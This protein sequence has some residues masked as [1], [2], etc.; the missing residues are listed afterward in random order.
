MST[1]PT[2]LILVFFIGVSFLSVY[3]AQGVDELSNK[4]S[5]KVDHQ[6]FN[7]LLKNH[8]STSGEVN[9][10]AFREHST[11]FSEYL[12]ILTKANPYAKNWSRNE[13]LAFWINAYNAF[14]IQLILDNMPLESIKDIYRPWNKKFFS[15]AGIEIDLNHVEHEILRKMN[16]PRIHFAIV[17][18]SYSCPQLR[19]EA[20][21]A[22]RLEEQ[23][24]QQASQFINDPKRNRI[25]KEAVELS[26]IFDW[27]TKDFTANGSLIDFINQYSKVK[28]SKDA[29]ISWLD[30]NWK[31]ND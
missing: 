13:R 11:R 10:K 23:L 19:N 5:P 31:L 30:Y 27:F 16:E 22:S 2:F 6:I 1:K 14:T 20:Y 21:T 26:K 3:N 25:S 17:C 15:I 12:S 7:E 8:V 9:Y 18:A 24:K 28:V 29:D 4:I